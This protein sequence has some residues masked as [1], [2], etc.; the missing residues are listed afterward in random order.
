MI[1]ASITYVQGADRMLI[2]ARLTPEGVHV[3]FADEREGIVPFEVLELGGPPD[4]VLLP[5][6]HVIEVHLLGGKVEEIPWD[7]ARHHVDPEYRRTSEAT[8]KRGA[9][10][11]GERLRIL[12]TDGGITQEQLSRRSGVHRV[13]IARIETGE[14]LPRYQT[15]DALAAAL[16]LSVDTLIAG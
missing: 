10:T 14:Q 5:N 7:F 11:F 16:G 13:T 2:G 3:R 15:L 12:R 6:P 4:H 1:S 8:A 9:H